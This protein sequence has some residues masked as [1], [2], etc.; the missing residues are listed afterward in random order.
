MLIDWVADSPSGFVAA[1][2]RTRWTE[3]LMTW[4]TR[5]SR[6]WTASLRTLP[7]RLGT[8]ATWRSASHPTTLLLCFVMAFTP[9]F[10]PK[11][12]LPSSRHPSENYIF[13]Y[14]K[15]KTVF[16]WVPRNPNYLPFCS[17]RN[18]VYLS[19][20]PLPHFLYLFTYFFFDFSSFFFI[21]NNLYSFA[22][23]RVFFGRGLWPLLR[24]R[25][26]VNR[27][28]CSRTWKEGRE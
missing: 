26:N 1:P 2:R 7:R 24:G 14:S 4:P 3:S 9:V 5:R 22:A 20:H 27:R 13:F 23:V 18:P 11:I 17:L 19:F 12:F 25:R 6:R 15:L 8:S 10:Q 28:K 16:K 21:Y